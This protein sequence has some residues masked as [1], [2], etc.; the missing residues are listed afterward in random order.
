MLTM[1]YNII[2]SRTFYIVPSCY[3][4]VWLWLWPVTSHF[5]FFFFFFFLYI[6]RFITWSA[7]V[8]RGGYFCSY[9]H[10]T[11][12]DMKRGK[13]KKRKREERKKEERLTKCQ[14]NMKTKE[15][16]VL[17]RDYTVIECESTWISI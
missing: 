1:P 3:M 6:Q 16:I 15:A 13:E 12:N 11:G 2:I 17:N 8:G 14:V 7:K 10:G 9:V 5:V 4:S